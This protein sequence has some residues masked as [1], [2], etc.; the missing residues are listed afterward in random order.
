MKRIIICSFIL[1]T[2]TQSSCVTSLQPLATHKTVITDDRLI[3][4]WKTDDREY[5]VQKFF[6]SDVYKRLKK[7]VDKNKDKKDGHKAL[8][9]KEKQDSVLYSKSY[10]V[11]YTKDKIQYYLFG[12]MVKLNGQL[13]IN[14]IVADMTMLENN[15]DA[16]EITLTDRLSTNTIARV[17]FSNPGVL[18]LDFI[19]GGFLYKQVN[20][21]RMKIKHETDALYDTFIITASTTELQQFI[22]KYSN[23]SR[24]FNKENSVTLN[25]KS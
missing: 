7:E 15:G 5:T 1:I 21:G 6:D 12:N 20:D 18:K 16:F 3:G 14:F 25:R 24:F 10:V 9:E 11:K 4:T 19:D 22:Q 13:F 23:D 17:Q 8:S 2:L